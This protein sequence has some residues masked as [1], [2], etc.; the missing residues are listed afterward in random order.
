MPQLQWQ[1]QMQQQCGDDSSPNMSAGSTSAL[2]AVTA[3][4]AA[5]AADRRVMSGVSFTGAYNAAAAQAA[6][7]QPAPTAVNPG[8]HGCPSGPQAMAQAAYSQPWAMMPPGSGPSGS[9]GPVSGLN[10]AAMVQAA[11]ATAAA[12]AGSYQAVTFEENAL[13][14]S[15]GGFIPDIDAEDAWFMDV[16]QA[17]DQEGGP[18][19][20]SRDSLVDMFVQQYERN[21][22][23]P[24]SKC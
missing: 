22:Q 21:M 20:L 13:A 23:Y 10:P 8:G 4:E 17:T 6:G 5:T 14:N 7:L 19:G 18:V 11:A 15:A 3:A 24:V 1:Q 12:T 16:C 2:A 9:P